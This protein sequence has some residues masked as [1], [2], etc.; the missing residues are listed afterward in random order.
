[1]IEFAWMAF[2]A[3]M[4]TAGFRAL[5]GWISSSAADGKFEPG[6][7]D[8]LGILAITYI[9]VGIAAGFGQTLT[10]ANMAIIGSGAGFLIHE[11]LRKILKK[12]S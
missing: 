12:Q 9:V 11:V 3:V 10:E 1:M 5:T 6:E 7:W 4:G 8:A 2:W